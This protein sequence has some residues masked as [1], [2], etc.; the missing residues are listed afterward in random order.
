M[1]EY[2]SAVRNR[3][4]K[5]PLAEHYNLAHTNDDIRIKCHALEMVNL[6]QRDGNRVAVLRQKEAKWLIRIGAV[7]HDLNIDRELHNFLSAL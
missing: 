4:N 1:Q 2:I 6:P 3:D 5:Y 7:D